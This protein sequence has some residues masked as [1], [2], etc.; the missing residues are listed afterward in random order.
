[1]P[2]D[3]VDESLE[4]RGGSRDAH[5]GERLPAQRRVHH[6]HQRAPDQRL[7]HADLQHRKKRRG[8]TVEPACK[9]HGSKAF[10]DVW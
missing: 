8:N 6:P 5:D 3:E 2:G 7:H 1:M 10:S 9:V 4:E